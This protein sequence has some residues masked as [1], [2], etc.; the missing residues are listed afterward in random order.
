MNSFAQYLLRID[1]QLQIVISILAASFH[2]C[3]MFEQ[4]VRETHACM[5][6]SFG[7]ITLI[8]LQS[9]CKSGP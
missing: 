7:I 9:E 1:K 2:S 8:G 5:G 4:S 3:K 6:R